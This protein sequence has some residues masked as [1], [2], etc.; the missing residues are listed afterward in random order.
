[1]NTGTL[2]AH[3]GSVSAECSTLQGKGKPLSEVLTGAKHVGLTVW[4]I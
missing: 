2:C 4:E 3:R 1:M